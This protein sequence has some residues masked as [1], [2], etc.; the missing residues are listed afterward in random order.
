MPSNCQPDGKS[1]Q[2]LFS[3]FW[4]SAWAIFL[5][6]SWLLPSHYQPW[7]GFHGDAL[8]SLAMLIGGGAVMVG[9]RDPVRWHW[10][11]VLALM[12]ALIPFV[13]YFSGLVFFLG[14]AWVSA[15]YLLGFCLALI[16]GE[17][18]ESIRKDQAI[19]GLFLAIGIAAIASVG[20]Q[21][22]QW[23]N[24]EGL[25][26][27]VM[28]SVYGRP[29]ANF[30][31]PNKLG[32]FLLLGLIASG[33]G[34]FR[35][36]IGLP[37]ALLMS[38]F[39]VFGI[40]L[41][42]SRTALFGMF[43]LVFLAFFWQKYIASRQVLFGLVGLLIFLLVSYKG[44]PLISEVLLIDSQSDR[45][46][47]VS[48]TLNAG[49]RPSAYRLFLGAALAKPWFGYGWFHVASAQFAVVDQFPALGTVFLHSH[50]LFLDL[51]LWA[52]WPVGGI[53]SIA[54][55]VWMVLSFRAVRDVKAALLMMAVGVV[56]WHAML[57][58]PLHYATFLLPM[59]LVM[60]VL[61]SKNR[62]PNVILQSSWWQM[63][64]LFGVA[65]TMLMVV[66][67]DYFKVEKNLTALRFERSIFGKQLTP[68][69]PPDVLAL[70]QLRGFLVM[71]RFLP[72]PGMTSYEIESFRQSAIAVPNPANIF[73][74]VQI[75]VLNQRVD[76][77]NLWINILYKTVSP[78]IFNQM[79]LAWQNETKSNPVLAGV[80]WGSSE[81]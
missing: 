64:V 44:I 13:Q 63:L 45:F 4:L 52:G 48:E 61:N 73:R 51:V 15:L 79:A 9:S 1:S 60:G 27:W 14:Q 74:F 47:D 26:I 20:L 2:Y 53:L 40:A 12:S 69:A 67:V 34:Y 24:L 78:D 41:T 5:S 7:T 55:C 72:K 56:G 10:L 57:E 58:L 62:S 81:Q 43:L 3:S 33:W 36:K 23:F 6:L 70:T 31:Q 54:L 8:I 16:V 68:L 19:D 32:T 38:I 21:F 18:W 59:G 49:L 39:L 76:E 25:D 65:I 22:Y 11:A 42:Q 30:A 37:V 46:A 28:P 75:L 71:G 17:R 35:Q 80:S 66:I 50:N 77:A 29:Y